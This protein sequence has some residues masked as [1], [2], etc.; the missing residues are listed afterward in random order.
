MKSLSPEEVDAIDPT[1]IDSV[2]GDRLV[3]TIRSLRD[4]MGFLETMFSASSNMKV[5]LWLADVQGELA[6]AAKWA[7]SDVPEWLDLK[8][9]AAHSWAHDW[10]RFWQSTDS[11][12]GEK[13]KPCDICGAPATFRSGRMAACGK[14][15]WKAL[16]GELPD[17]VCRLCNRVVVCA[18]DLDGSPVCTDC[19]PGERLLS[20]RRSAFAKRLGVEVDGR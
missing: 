6:E 20:E 2:T 9:I 13:A 4:H 5:A 19:W 1:S 11:F 17:E 12:T 8:E 3:H 10:R 14:R 16:K 15:H 7:I 18:H